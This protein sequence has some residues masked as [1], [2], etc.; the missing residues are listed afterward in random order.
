[1]QG[2][3]LVMCIYTRKVAMT[4]R[5]TM[6][7]IVWLILILIIRTYQLELG[8]EIHPMINLILLSNFLL[9]LCR[10]PSLQLK[11]N[12]PQGANLFFYI[13]YYGYVSGTFIGWRRPISISHECRAVEASSTECFFK[14]AKL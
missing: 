2:Y 6:I 10:F 1:M 5:R 9:H 13:S 14:N 4:R 7:P 8:T 11:I 12:Y 3:N